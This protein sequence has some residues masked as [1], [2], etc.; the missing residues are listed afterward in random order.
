[1][2][3]LDLLDCCNDVRRYQWPRGLR[4]GSVAACLVGLRVRIMPG[5]WMSVVSGVL[6]G[7]GLCD[8][9]IPR[10]EEFY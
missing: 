5:A 6:S 9:P 10:P 8:R 1:M 4:R 3:K 2:S 7:G